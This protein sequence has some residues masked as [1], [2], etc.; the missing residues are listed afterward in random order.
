MLSAVLFC[1]V[2]RNH[3]VTVRVM[4]AECV[5]FVAAPLEV[6]RIV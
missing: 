5:S 4:G 3:L 6:T 1:T 2:I